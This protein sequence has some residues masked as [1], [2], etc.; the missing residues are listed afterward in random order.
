M[1]DGFSSVPVY[2]VTLLGDGAVGKTSLRDRFMGKVFPTEYLMTIGADFATKTLEISGKQAKFQI[3]DLAGQPRFEMVRG[4]YYKGAV[5]GMLVFDVTRPSSFENST[6]WIR[7]VWENNGKGK[8]PLVLLGN[9]VD[10]R[11]QVPISTRP[12]QGEKFAR[13]LSRIT[14]NGGFSIPYYE[15]SAKSGKNVDQAF[16]ALGEAVANFITTK[17]GKL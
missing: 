1:S 2:K 11:D 3:W 7:E 6:A 8:I 14:S 12:E 17:V 4:L 10:L 9:K 13:E 16:L 15:T 5:G